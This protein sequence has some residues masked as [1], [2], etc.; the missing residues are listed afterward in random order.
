MGWLMGCPGDDAPAETSSMTGGSATETNSGE[1]SGTAG[2]SE[3]DTTADGTSEPPP[4][5]DCQAPEQVC[6][7]ICA[8][9]DTDPNNCG[10]CG[11]SCVIPQATAACAAGECVLAGCDPG[12]SDCDGEIETGCETAIECQRG[13]S[14]ET[15]CGSEGTTDCTDV[16][17]SAGEPVCLEPEETCNVIDDNCDGACDEGAMEGCRVGVHRSFGPSLGHFYTTDLVEAQMGD[18][19]L[20]FEN[21]FWLYAPGV[22]G[23]VPLFRC[24]KPN[25]KRWLTSAVDCEIGVAPELTVGFISLD[26]RC[27]ATPLYRTLNPGPDAHFY[28]TSAAERD[29]AVDNLGFIDQGIEGYIWAAP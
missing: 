6:G 14:C 25:G 12:H 1:G 21:Y 29:N 4:P 24:V 28:T 15:R 23:L 22:E 20:E 10:V 17:A 27:G 3:G 2:S 18:L 16:C 26:D 8:D 11:R 5:P 13:A 9:L 7:A 19:N